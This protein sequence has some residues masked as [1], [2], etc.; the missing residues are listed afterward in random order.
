MAP[1]ARELSGGPQVIEMFDG[2]YGVTKWFDTLGD[3]VTHS[4][5]NTRSIY[6]ISVVLVG[7]PVSATEKSAVRVRSMK[8]GPGPLSEAMLRSHSV[9][10][11]G[12]PL[13]AGFTEA[14]AVYR[15]GL[16]DLV[17]VPRVQMEPDMPNG[18]YAVVTKGGRAMSGHAVVVKAG[19]QFQ[20]ETIDR[21]DI[22]AVYD[23]S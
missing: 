7:E 8:F 16:L 23:L 14:I 20:S 13:Q 6:V 21:F 12:V 22:E 19:L 5:E 9:D 10:P 17:G 4:E 1:G 18:T 3:A 11:K 2:S 15:V